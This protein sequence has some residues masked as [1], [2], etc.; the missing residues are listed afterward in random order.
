MTK[1]QE[2]EQKMNIQ[3]NKI[4]L[5]GGRL[6]ITEYDEAEHNISAHISPQ[7]W[8]TEVSV[9]KGFNPIQDKRQK[10]Y[11]KKKKIEDGLEILLSGVVTHE[12]GHWQLPYGS[13][14]GCPYDT[15]NHDKI[16]EAVKNALPEDKQGQADYVANAFEDVIDNAR[17][18]EWQGNLDGQVLF[19]DNEGV[20]CKQRGQKGFTPFYEAFVKLNLALSGDNYDKALLKRNYTR[21]KE[22]DKGIKETASD[23]NLKTDKDGMPVNLE[24][25]DSVYDKSRWPE[26]ANSFAKNLAH[27][28]EI[29]PTERL[30][31]FSSDNNGKG[32]GKEKEQEAGNGIQEKSKTRDGKEEIVYGRYSSGEPQSSNFTSYEQLDALYRKLAKPLAVRVEAM[33]KQQGLNIAPLTYRPFDEER[34]SPNKA[35]LSKLFVT[36]NGLTFAHQNQPLTISSRSKIQRKSFPDFKMVVLDN[37]GSMKES[38]DSSGVGRTEFI[39]WGDNSKY[40]F[41]LLGF[42]G[43]ENFLQQQGVAQYIQHGISLFSSTTRFK[44]AGFTGIDEIR[45]LA[46]KPEFGNTYLDA[47]TLEKALSG[48]ESF[49]LSLSDGEVGNWDSEKTK[50]TELAKKNHYAH[51]QIGSQSEF[52]RDLESAGFPVFYVGNGNDLSKLMVDITKK[53][54]NQFVRSEK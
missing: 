44:E 52:S 54:Y 13:G 29:S 28:L 35:K 24:S 45:K 6:K 23:W 15:Y 48:R 42:Y 19:W 33:S 21:A 34:D 16:L 1:I 39:P 30:S 17:G 31:A 8:N 5:V 53:T 50:F 10:A 47:K 37:S 22:I 51:I 49:V 11:S 9:K 43:I 25:T 32:S 41:A 36:D 14:K 27:L 7:G 40:H 46:L 2:I 4:G 18:R 20:S 12:F 26:M 38:I 3:K